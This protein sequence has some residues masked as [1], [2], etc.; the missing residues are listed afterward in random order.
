M[1]VRRTMLFIPLA[2]VAVAVWTAISR[3]RARPYPAL[4]AW[5]L[6]NP[7]SARL[8]GTQTTLDQI[9]LRPGQR[10]LEI[11]PG[12]GRLLIPAAELVLPGGVATGLEVQSGMVQMLRQHATQAGAT[13]VIVV[14]GD[15]TA[16]H[17]PPESFDV[18]YLCAVLGEIADRAAVL[19]HCYAVL[20]PG[21]ALSITEGWPDPHYQPRDVVQRLAETTGFR[22]INVYDGRGRYTAN[23]VRP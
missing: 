3:R 13:N 17:F 15:A 18:V 8:L 2:L 7:L 10:V 9:G 4:F 19:R 12:S 5:L 6:D 11:G 23:F 20:K 1:R 22:A 16:P 21:G 14:Q